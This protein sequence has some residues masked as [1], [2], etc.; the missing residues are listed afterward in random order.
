MGQIIHFYVCTMLTL[1]FCASRLSVERINRS[2][3]DM[4]AY[5]S[6]M[7]GIVYKHC[8]HAFLYAQHSIVR[9]DIVRIRSFNPSR[10]EVRFC[11]SSNIFRTFDRLQ[12]GRGGLITAVGD[13]RKGSRF[14]REHKSGVGVGVIRFYLQL[15]C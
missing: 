5:Y 12:N 3:R 11:I 9:R 1:R 13:R 6:V 4:T 14:Q 15:P 2:R 10:Y 7:C 8:V